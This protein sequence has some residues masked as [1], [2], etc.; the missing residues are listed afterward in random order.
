LPMQPP[1][2]SAPAEMYSVDETSLKQVG[3]CES[4]SSCFGCRSDQAIECADLETTMVG[5]RNSFQGQ[6][7]NGRVS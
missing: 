5:A 3:A 1:G 2:V 7:A 4:S 6:G